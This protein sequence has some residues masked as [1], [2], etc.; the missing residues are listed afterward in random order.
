[1][2]QS[3]IWPPSSGS[4][5]KPSKNQRPLTA[6]LPAFTLSLFVDP[7]DGGYMFLRNS[8][9]FQRTAWVISQN[10]A[11]FITTA[12]RTLNPR[13]HDP[14]TIFSSHKSNNFNTVTRNRL[15]V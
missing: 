14:Y 4:K 11:L 13:N 7:E 2:F 8:A 12:V 6:L 10:I 9:D 1:M 15:A 3:N 5:N